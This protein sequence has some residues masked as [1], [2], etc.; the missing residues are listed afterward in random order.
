[1]RERQPFGGPTIVQ[2]GDRDVAL[3]GQLVSVMRVALEQS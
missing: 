3:G 2:V 1:V